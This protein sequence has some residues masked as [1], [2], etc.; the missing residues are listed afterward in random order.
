MTEHDD[1]ETGE[2]PVPRLSD[3]E[4]LLRRVA[5]MISSAKTMPLSSSAMINRDEILELLEEANNRLPEELRAARWLLRERDEFLAKTRREGDDILDAARAQAERMVQ[6][7]EV[8]RAAQQRARQI[9]T[10]SEDEARRLRHEVEDYCDQRLGQ[11][12]VILDKVLKTVQAGR[13][14]LIPTGLPEPDADEAEAA[15]EH[16]AVFFDQ[17][18]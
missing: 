2:H 8:V 6:R 18:D 9:V 12:E 11:F 15:A 3:S 17:D 13:D 5:D 16:E 4:A 14:R 7:T 1:E 10:T